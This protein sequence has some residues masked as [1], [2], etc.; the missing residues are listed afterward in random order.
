DFDGARWLDFQ[1]VPR[2]DAKRIHDSCSSYAVPI[3]RASTLWGSR[4]AEAKPLVVSAGMGRRQPAHYAPC[5]FHPPINQ[6]I[7][8][9]HRQV[10]LCSRAVARKLASSTAIRS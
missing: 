3:V 1:V 4:A 2:K 5:L 9:G 10:R 6:R 8:L 7:G